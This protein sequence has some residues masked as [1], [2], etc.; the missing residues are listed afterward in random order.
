MH[1]VSCTMNLS[2]LIYR[3][4]AAYQNFLMIL[5][6][7]NLLFYSTVTAKNQRGIKYSL[8]GIELVHPWM[9][10]R[11]KMINWLQ[12][13]CSIPASDVR[14]WLCWMDA[15]LWKHVF[16]YCLQTDTKSSVILLACQLHKHGVLQVWWVMAVN[17]HCRAVTFLLLNAHLWLMSWQT[18]RHSMVRRKLYTGMLK[19]RVKSVWL[20]KA[21]RL[22]TQEFLMTT[23]VDNEFLEN[24]SKRSTSPFTTWIPRQSHLRYIKTLSQNYEFFWTWEL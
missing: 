12:W 10:A 21:Q 3:C 20:V 1:H 7:G 11:K 16:S 4:L 23:Q 17:A 19:Q 14:V 9:Y 22:V 8:G 13:V 15:A 5:V 24:V 6:S 18:T 2:C